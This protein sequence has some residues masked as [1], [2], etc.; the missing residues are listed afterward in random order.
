[1]PAERG[2][3]LGDSLSSPLAPAAWRSPSVVPLGLLGLAFIVAIWIGT[4]LLLQR[5]HRA[6]QER[7]RHGLQVQAEAA[8][9][10]TERALLTIENTLLQT[11]LADR[12]DPETTITGVLRD[13]AANGRMVDSIWVADA[14]GRV[15]LSNESAAA[16]GAVVVAD[17]LF[18]RLSQSDAPPHDADL[19]PTGGDR[20]RIA[21]RLSDG[22]GRFGG[23]AVATISPAALL[24][25]VPAVPTNDG[26]PV[27]LLDGGGAVL[28]TT[29]GSSS[30]AAGEPLM[31]IRRGIAGLPLS[32]EVAGTPRFAM[33]E[34]AA[35]RGALLAGAGTASFVLL[36]MTLALVRSLIDR[37]M[38]NRDAR[39]MSNV[40][41]QVFES[42]PAGIQIKDAD[43]RYTWA[44]RAFTE[45]SGLSLDQLRG[46][47]VDDLD[48]SPQWATTANEHD[49]RV[50]AAGTAEGPVEQIIE[51]H[52]GKTLYSLI[53]KVPLLSDGRVT[54]IVT[55][56]ADVTPVREAQAASEQAQRLLEQ[57]INAV[58]V[59][60]H[61]KD[62]D[63]RYRWAN[64]TF[65][66]LFGVDPLA[67]IG[68]RTE[69]AFAGD[70]NARRASRRDEEVLATGGTIGPYE[71]DVNDAQGRRHRLIATKMPLRDSSGAVVQVLTV[72]VDISERKLAEEAINRL[73][74]ELEQRVADRTADLAKAN[75]LL[76]KVIAAAPIPIVT[77]DRA[78]RITS[79]N[80][81]AERVT[82]YAAGEVIGGE[83]PL[84]DDAARA[85]F[86][87]LAQRIA[88]GESHFSTET[89]RQH[90]DG[91]T[92]E[93]IIGGAPLY[94]VNGEI[95]GAV[96][97]WLDVTEQRATQRQL[98]QAQK[99]EAVGQLTGGIAHDFNNLLSV[100]IGNLDMAVETADLAAAVDLMHESLAAA[101][102]GAELTRRLLAFA[103]PKMAAPRRVDPTAVIDAMRPML[104]SALGE[105]VSIRFD[106]QPAVWPIEIDPSQLESALLNLCV[107]SRD[108]MPDGGTVTV[109]VGNAS[110][111]TSEIL[112]GD[113]VRIDVIDT[114]HGMPPEAVARAFEPFFTTK[115]PG[116][117]T[118]LGLSMVYGF[119][120]QSGGAVGIDSR[121][122]AGTTVSLCLPRARPSPDAPARERPTSV[123]VGGGEM[124]LVVE[125]NADLA[126]TVTHQLDQ[127]GYATISAGN[128]DAA[129]GVLRGSR[130][131]DLLFSDIVMP[132]ALD[133]RGLAQMAA[134]LRPGLRCLLTSGYEQGGGPLRA[135]TAHLPVLA[136]PY[137][138]DEL[139]R[140]IR[141]ALDA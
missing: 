61:V 63:H 115:Q 101:E 49:R 52:D 18:R 98:Q 117:G 123:P 12:L 51:R 68:R 99:M 27:A 15:R 35:W 134:Q 140:A 128:A 116:K 92:I 17:P 104:A 24:R 122:G 88:G 14:G 44:N 82:G 106:A 95:D 4:L 73:N 108:A 56:G 80:S 93:L 45:R 102:R 72:G 83:L 100:I 121:P 126:R 96:G 66:E 84:S 10:A 139:A 16:Q 32:I 132:G 129:L 25:V 89:R 20:L 30:Q 74:R 87:A 120:R 107:N 8:T 110:M 118:G 109:R 125:D 62:A 69:D 60:I 76:S 77:Y 38:A 36:A 23:I 119:V 53:T 42:F 31:T 85:D 112:A 54:H 9:F 37:E 75:E 50:L 47:R 40:M 19:T 2:T 7:A 136:K 137:R 94:G 111:G 39:A 41:Q 138:R 90:K 46:K 124:I 114:G 81:A 59:S 11:A 133:G 43:L 131:I 64:R 29:G 22:D 28:A 48:I 58:P 71:A 26:T 113:H 57:V 34:F 1:M 130:T 103:R 33:A 78:G 3:S 5:E 21:K 127:L 135:A 91:R 55:I 79:W 65:A 13:A 97:I 67:I 86:S 6:A 70:P 141:A 105:R